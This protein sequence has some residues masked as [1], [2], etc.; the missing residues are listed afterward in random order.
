MCYRR[1]LIREKDC[2]VVMGQRENVPVMVMG[3]MTVTDGMLMKDSMKVV[4]I[5]VFCACLDPF[6]KCPPFMKGM[7]AGSRY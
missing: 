7:Q 2:V 4:D 1:M 3:K 6:W 5:F